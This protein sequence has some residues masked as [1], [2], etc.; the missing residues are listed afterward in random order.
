KIEDTVV[1]KIKCGADSRVGGKQFFHFKFDVLRHR[2][3]AALT[4]G[5]KTG[6]QVRLH[7]NSF[8]GTAEA[9]RADQIIERQI[10]AYPHRR[11]LEL[12]VAGVP[13][14]G[15]EHKPHVDLED[16]RV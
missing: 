14:S 7:E 6:V 10:F 9:Q 1:A 13:R 15:V 8:F 3:E 11:K 4:L 16:A 12:R 5:I 2:I